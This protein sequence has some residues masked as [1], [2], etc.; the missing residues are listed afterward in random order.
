MSQ[1][2]KA[3]EKEID[4]LQVV[5]R[6]LELVTNALIRSDLPNSVTT[7]DAVHATR[8]DST[9]QLLTKAVPKR[10]I[11]PTEKQLQSY[12]SVF[13]ELSVE[14]SGIVLRGDLIVVPKALQ[15]KVVQ[16]AHEGHQ[17]I[18]KT[19]QLIHSTIWFPGTDAAVQEAVERCLLCQ[20]ATDTKQK[21]PLLPTG[22]PTAP[23]LRV[24]TDLFG[25]IAGGQEYV[26][27]VQDLYSRYPAVEIVHSTSAKAVLPAMDRMM[28]M[29]GIPEYV[30]SD[31]GPQY[32]SDVFKQFARY[33]GFE[34]GSKIPLAPWTNGMVEHFMHNMVKVLQ[35]SQ[36]QHLSWLQE[37]QR[38][39][40]SYRATPHAMTGRSPAEVVF[41]G[42]QYR[43][44]LPAKHS[45][46]Q[47]I[48][49]Q[50]IRNKDI[51]TSLFSY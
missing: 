39:L 45:K 50:E 18:V 13:Q 8:Q 30:A 3:S 42:R 32:N 15:Q 36:K 48:Y 10:Y 9:L 26:L 19:K 34:H 51:C 12:K 27:V 28:S 41:N 14:D 23:W 29:L 33:M 44:R 4:G 24:T 47:P 7:D 22:L 21:E 40:R 1:H 11:V 2:P 31:N 49:H 43:T 35:T 46:V 38:F 25:S 37:L 20:T 5:E 6:Q 16:L 17:G